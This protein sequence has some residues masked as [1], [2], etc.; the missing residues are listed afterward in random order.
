LLIHGLGLNFA[1]KRG[2]ISLFVA[3]HKAL[4]ADVREL[5]NHCATVDFVNKKGCTT[6]LVA[7]QKDHMEFAVELLNHHVTRKGHHYSQLL[8]AAIWTYYV[9]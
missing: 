1:D 8:T 5:L 7:A 4:L 9:K 6:F 2:F 3:V